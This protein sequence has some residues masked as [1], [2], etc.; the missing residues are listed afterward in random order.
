MPIRTRQLDMSPSIAAATVDASAASLT[1][2]EIQMVDPGAHQCRLS[3]PWA[4][5]LTQIC[6]DDPH[7][8]HRGSR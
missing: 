4:T 7:M 3:T 8:W 5:E 1:S 6:G 2:V